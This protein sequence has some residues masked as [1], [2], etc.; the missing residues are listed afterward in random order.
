MWPRCLMASRRKAGASVA[1]A[2]R[3][4]YIQRMNRAERSYAYY[5]RTARATGRERRRMRG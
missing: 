1:S 2:R 5:Y 4:M 3:S